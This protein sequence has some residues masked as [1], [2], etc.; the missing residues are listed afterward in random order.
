MVTK[1]LFGQILIYDDF[2]GISSL[3]YRK[4][5]G[6][7]SNHPGETVGSYVNSFPMPRFF[8]SRSLFPGDGLQPFSPSLRAR[9]HPICPSL[10]EFPG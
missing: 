6:H 10:Y 2:Q 4:I 8:I 3:V 5:V 1:N 7:E 9:P